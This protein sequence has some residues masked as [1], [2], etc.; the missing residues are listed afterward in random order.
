MTRREFLAMAGAFAASRAFGTEDG[1]ETPLVRFG[2]VTDLHYADIDTAGSGATA[3]HYRDSLPK[4]TAAVADFNKR[5]EDLVVELGDFKDLTNGRDGT[6]AAL[7]RIETEFAKFEGPRYHVPGNHDFDCLTE[8]EFY[9]RTPNG[10]SVGG[11]YYSFVRN[12]VTFIVLD[13]CYTSDAK[14]YSPAISWSWTDSNI[15]PDEMEW[16]GRELAAAQ[17]HVV[18]FC[19][20]RLD[21]ASDPDCRVKN[22]AEVRSLLEASGKVRAVL[23]GHQHV[24]GQDFVN[25]ISYYTL[26]AMVSGAWPDSNCY[27]E[28]AVYPSGKF[29]IATN[30]VLLPPGAVASSTRT[31]ALYTSAAAAPTFALTSGALSS[32][33]L[34]TYRDGETVTVTSPS[35][36]TTTL[37]G[38][39]GKIEYAPAS[40]GLWTF[41]NSNGEIAHVGVDGSVHGDA[42]APVASSASFAADAVGEGPD[43][44]LKNS[45]TPPVAYSGDDWKGDFSKAATVTFTP[46]DGSGLAAT[47]WN[48]T[49]KGAEPF[50]FNAKGVWTVT[51]KFANN[52]T[53]TA[54]IDI[55]AA[56]LTLIFK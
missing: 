55:Q 33:F 6:L 49:G 20:Q 51:L 2:L 43:R 45:E 15:P 52:T 11:G 18:V 41:T 8:E 50:T 46:P 34:I 30:D 24:G 14:H 42:P 5:A 21:P 28:A 26:G 36:V 16:L 17:G 37:S 13:G 39:G 48:R 54:H 25:G 1:S 32:P 29:T 53:R 19:H 44:K 40:G 35:G 38:V 4:L 12:G 27:A 9:S 56:G 7:E 10:G 23:A 22:A 47:T 31:F 3:R